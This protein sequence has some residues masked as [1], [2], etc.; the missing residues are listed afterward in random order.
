M[1]TKA[2]GAYNVKKIDKKRKTKV[3]SV[4]KN[5]KDCTFEMFISEKKR[6][7]QGCQRFETSVFFSEKI[8]ISTTGGFRVSFL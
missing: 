5:F 4:I 8:N 7:C 6:V 1:Q 2:T 3:T